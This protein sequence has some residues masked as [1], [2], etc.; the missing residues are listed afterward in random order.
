LLFFK[1]LG[2][3][4]K[5]GEA[6]SA[7]LKATLQNGELK[8]ITGLKATGPNLQI[9]NAN[10]MFGKGNALSGGSID[11]FAA[12]ETAAKLKFDVTPGR[13]NTISPSTDRSLTCGLRWI[14]TLRRRKFMT[15]RRCR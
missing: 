4:K 3:E 11:S 9:N 1:P 13:E 14:M 10:F 12:G 8:T 5:P 15:S 2:Y 7:T 6:G